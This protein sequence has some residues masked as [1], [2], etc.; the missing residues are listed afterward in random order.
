MCQQ[1]SC[2]YGTVDMS[3]GFCPCPP[4]DELCIMRRQTVGDGDKDEDGSGDDYAD[5]HFLYYNYYF[6]DDDSELK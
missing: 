4:L 5:E 6:N 1:P 2:N 3:V